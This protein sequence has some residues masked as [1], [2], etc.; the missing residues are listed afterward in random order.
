M[1]PL[2]AAH[3]IFLG[4]WGGLVMVEIAFEAQMFRGRMDEKSVA[5]LH[6]ITDRFIE[7][8]I[9]A[10]VFL[11]GWLLWEQ[12]GFDQALLPKILFGLG[13]VLVNV[14]CYVIVEIRAS[15]ALRAAN[16]D[17]GSLRLR[18]LSIILAITIAPGV[19][20]GGIALFLG[21][22]RTGWW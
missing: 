7:L 2:A 4:L 16:S 3:I 6:R 5:G 11:T 18:R 13:A 12:T 9:L 19:L 8:P 14:I 22:Q 15:E 17:G 21:G 10:A 1:D 20:S